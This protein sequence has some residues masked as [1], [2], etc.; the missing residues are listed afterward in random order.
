MISTTYILGSDAVNQTPKIYRYSRYRHHTPQ[1]ITPDMVRAMHN[2]QLSI[3]IILLHQFDTYMAL[4]GQ[5]LYISL[6]F[7]TVS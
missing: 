3:L 6:T 1:P 5:T 2:G 7:L 4:S